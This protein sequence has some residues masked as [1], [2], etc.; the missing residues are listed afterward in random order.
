[1]TKKYFKESEPIVRG[2]ASIA[3]WDLEVRFLC[4]EQLEKFV[5]LLL[6]DE[7]M[8]NVE[9]ESKEGDSVTPTE[10]IVSIYDMSWANNLTRVGKMLEKVDYNA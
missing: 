9:I 3:H 10:Y 4:K 8:F 1:M 2:R 7:L 5:K 6:K